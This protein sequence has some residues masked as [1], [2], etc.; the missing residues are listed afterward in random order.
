MAGS[1]I[2]QMKRIGYYSLYLASV[3]FVLAALAC[4]E[5]LTTDDHTVESVNLK[6]YMGK[7]YE[8]ASLPAPFQKDCYCT[9]AEYNLRGEYIEVINSCRRGSAEGRL[10]I[11]TGKAWPLKGS[12][13]SR[14]KVSFFWPFK[15][16]YWVVSLDQDYQWAM[17]GHPERKY[18]W[19]L[20]R[21]PEMSNDLYQ[22]LI[23]KA[24]EL[25]YNIENLK[26]MVQC[27]R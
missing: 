4:Q 27:P 26:L 13:N 11:A 8:I 19:I 9:T 3:I 24:K 21:K 16:D 10:D 20:S 15:G 12:N 25:G 7:W 17:I 5:E 22:S 6:R 18:L 2:K 23:K 14:L 1:F